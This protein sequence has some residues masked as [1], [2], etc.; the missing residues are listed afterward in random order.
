MFKESVSLPVFNP[1][2]LAHLQ[3][4]KHQKTYLF[5]SNSSVNFTHF[6]L[7]DHLHLLHLGSQIAAALPLSRRTTEVW[8][9][10]GVSHSQ[11]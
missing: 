3:P 5:T 6:F 2:I 4:N 1:F 7:L 8:E 10:V 11:G 9:V